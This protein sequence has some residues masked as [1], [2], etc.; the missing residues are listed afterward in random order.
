MCQHTK[1]VSPD[2]NELYAAGSNSRIGFHVADY[3]YRNL[4][5]ELFEIQPHKQANPRVHWVDIHRI[6]RKQAWEILVTSCSLC[7]DPGI[8]TA[9]P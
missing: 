7:L 9:G 5:T 3:Q 8:S 4:S 6:S 2:S 1:R